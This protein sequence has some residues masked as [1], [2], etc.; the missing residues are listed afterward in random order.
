M[1]LA[2]MT[3]LRNTHQSSTTTQE[4]HNNIKES[5]GLPNLHEFQEILYIKPQ[6]NWLPASHSN[7]PRAKKLHSD[8]PN[9]CKLE[10]QLVMTES[11]RLHIHT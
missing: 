5:K 1:F 11:T 8:H 10:V 7:R 9:S 4:A 6:G 2:N 3:H